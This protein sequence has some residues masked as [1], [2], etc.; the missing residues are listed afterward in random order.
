MPTTVETID[1]HPVPHPTAAVRQ[2][3]FALDDPYLEH[4]WAPIIGPSSTLLLRRCPPL[5]RHRLPASVPAED[6][7]RQLGLGHGTGRTSPLWRTLERVVRFRFAAMPAPGEL[8]VYTEVPPV[9]ARQLEHLPVWCR[10]QHDRLLTHHLARLA[11]AT[12][13]TS[14]APAATA[15]PSRI[16]DRLERLAHQSPTRRALSR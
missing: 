8:H 3:G 11:A 6:L 15:E 12:Q 16:A 5:W 10:R 13:P 4:C 2:A 14:A 1:L 7:A 9:P